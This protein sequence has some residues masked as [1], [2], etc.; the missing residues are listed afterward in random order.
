[1]FRMS[2]TS[3]IALCRQADFVHSPCLSCA[4]YK[5]QKPVQIHTQNVHSQRPPLLIT[6]HKVLVMLN[7]TVKPTHQSR[8]NVCI[9]KHQIKIT[10]PTGPQGLPCGPVCKV[11]FIVIFI[12][13]LAEIKR[14]TTPLPCA[15]GF[16]VIDNQSL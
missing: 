5:L 11:I 10:L 16:N 7:R 1:M 3:C 12:T 4:V 6:M 15:S 14:P 13:R 8:N 9:R 2:Y